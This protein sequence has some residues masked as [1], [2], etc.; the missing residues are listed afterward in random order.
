M[1][2]RRKS[3][4]VSTPFEQKTSDNSLGPDL[5]QVPEAVVKVVVNQT[6]KYSESTKE[7]A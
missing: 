3:H 7:I 1:T 2:K 4:S 6:L 5:T